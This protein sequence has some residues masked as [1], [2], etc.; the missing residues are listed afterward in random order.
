MACTVLYL[1]LG[2]IFMAILITDPIKY[3]LR[4]SMVN[5]LSIIFIGMH[6]NKYND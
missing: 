6:R 4:E 2:C 3:G 5:V 1:E